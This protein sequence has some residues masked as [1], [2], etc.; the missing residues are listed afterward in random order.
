LRL[1]PEGIVEPSQ[2]RLAIAALAS[3]GAMLGAGALLHAAPLPI[4]FLVPLA[5]FA[6]AIRV[7]GLFAVEDGRRIW[8]A[9]RVRGEPSQA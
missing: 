7:T 1:A 9:A 8:E 6:V 4:R 3:A 5:V 2:C